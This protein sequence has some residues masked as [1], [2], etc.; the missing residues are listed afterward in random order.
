MPRAL[1]PLA[2][3]LLAAAPAAPQVTYVESSAGLEEPGMDSGRTEVEMGDVDGDGHVDLVSIGDHGSPFINSDQHGVMV[4][5]GDGAG[6]WSV[7]QHGTFGYGGVALGDANGD[8]LMDVGY[9]MHHDYSG[10]DLGDQLI[11]VALGDGTG[12]A[13]T[14]WDDGLATAGESWGMFG[15][16][17]ADVDADGDLDLA[18]VSFGCCSG[19]SVYLNQG[20]GS[21]TSSFRV[22]GGN[23]GE[24][25]VF[26]EVD[27]DGYPDL[28]ASHDAGTVY[29]GDGA[30]GFALADADLPGSDYRLGP[31]LG[32][33]DGDGRDDLA[34]TTSGRVRVFGRAEEGTWYPLE[35]GLPTGGDWQAT[36]LHDMDG[37][38][39]VDLAAFGDGRFALWL[40][41]GG[42]NWT[43]ETSFTT[44]S[45]GDFAAFRV[46]GDADHNGRADVVIVADEGGLFNSQNVIRFFRET[47]VAETLSVR[48]VH[49]PAG[50]AVRAGSVRFV[51]WASAVPGGGPSGAALAYSVDGGPW[52][53]IATGV[54]NNG[55]F[56]WVVPGLAPTDDLR[57]AVVVAVPGGERAMATSG[58]L[59]VVR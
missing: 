17:F 18:S 19:I 32:D 54:P 42:G 6:S 44:P 21:W 53:P 47:S 37:D 28:A 9:G 36:E 3:L 50:A 56:Q 55:R 52:T 26:G 14:A 41:D 12:T 7:V 2:A 30:G 59:R 1:A 5:F 34:W 51:D 39:H 58:P 22:E 15:T 38:G 29:L 57:L 16:D 46:G 33:V 45:P 11:E 4:W 27:G 49:P 24:E 8:G 48:L 31:S 13:W 20:D 23:S 43:P 35:G 40:G 25:I 10:T